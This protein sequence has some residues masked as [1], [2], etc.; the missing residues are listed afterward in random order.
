MTELKQCK[1]EE[2]RKWKPLEKFYRR[3]RSA[4]GRDHWCR[5]CRL[6]Y[7]QGQ[8]ETKRLGKFMPGVDQQMRAMEKPPRSDWEVRQ[9]N[10]RRYANNHKEKKLCPKCKEQGI[11]AYIN[12]WQ[13]RWCMKHEGEALEKERAKKLVRGK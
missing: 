9:E 11:E 3:T 8:R 7:A 4:D 1:R 12:S 2:C 10:D 6:S 13:K 5:E